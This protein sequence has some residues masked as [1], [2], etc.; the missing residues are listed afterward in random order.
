MPSVH[1]IT[2]I[3]RSLGWGVCGSMYVTVK[4][5]VHIQVKG[6]WVNMSQLRYRKRLDNLC[7]E[8]CIQDPLS[9]RNPKA[10]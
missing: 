6:G 7:T 8:K 2:R 3:S 4:G 1:V 10:S 5:W 9:I